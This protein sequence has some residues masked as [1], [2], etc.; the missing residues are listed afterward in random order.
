MSSFLKFPDFVIS[1]TYQDRLPIRNT[2]LF[3]PYDN[4][5]ED[6]NEMKN[7]CSNYNLLLKSTDVFLNRENVIFQT[8]PHHYMIS[9]SNRYIEFD[10]NEI[11]DCNYEYNKCVD[12]GFEAWL[13]KKKFYDIMTDF[14][15]RDLIDNNQSI[16]FKF[17]SLIINCFNNAIDTYRKQHNLDEEDIF[18]IYKGGT[19]MKILWEKYKH[20][21]NY[22]R[23][24][25]DDCLNK[26]FKRS[27]SDYGIIIN[28]DF[29]NQGRIR[30]FNYHYYNINLMTF[31]IL[32]KINQE[33]NDNKLDYFLFSKIQETDLVDLLN[34][35]NDTLDEIKQKA[36]DPQSEIDDPNIKVIFKKSNLDKIKK[37]VGIAIDN[38][39]FIEESY[40]YKNLDFND[41]KD[42]SNKKVNIPINNNIDTKKSN[43]LITKKD[44]NF[45]NTNIL[46]NIG[47]K[48]NNFYYYNNETPFFLTEG[49]KTDDTNWRTESYGTFSLHRIKL[50]AKLLG[51]TNNNEL[52]LLSTPSE[53]VDISI[54]KYNDFKSLEYTKYNFEKLWQKFNYKNQISYISFTFYGFLK[55][56]MAI[57]Y[58]EKNFKPWDDQK[59]SKRIVRT[60]V[61]LT[62]ILFNLND[63]KNTRIN[64]INHFVQKIKNNID[65]GYSFTGKDN[66]MIL[67]F[68]ENH[69]KAKEH[70][71][72]E[73]SKYT[74]YE[75]IIMKFFTKLKE[76]VEN[77]PQNVLSNITEINYLKKYMKYKLK[78]LQLKKNINFNL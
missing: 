47:N 43:F 70:K 46:I 56:L 48:Q 31:N 75:N 3:K 35:S 64:I 13:L 69:E 58:T 44:H 12:I 59:Y 76:N 9:Q 34:K 40:R 7:F 49:K 25:F 54:S 73:L 32:N 68:F 41:L 67:E 4:N 30:E 27:D 38:K 19:T 37:F 66:K 72:T 15:N 21:F 28:N 2:N 17:Q 36:N 42:I 22:D 8:Q 24:Y 1:D 53:V 26:N 52:V 51:L 71:N 57:I 61:F 77:K 16:I 60:L 65:D 18:F 29:V 23:E 11:N 63:E 33:F 14:I 39:V 74:K 10:K 5:I 45:N 50:G 20:L 62:L 6:N 55:D 78:Y